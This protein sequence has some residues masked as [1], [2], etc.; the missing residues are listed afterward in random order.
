MTPEEWPTSTDPMA[1][2]AVMYLSQS[3]RKL[4][5]FAVACARRVASFMD[6][7]GDVAAMDTAEQ[8]ADGRASL[9]Q[10]RRLGQ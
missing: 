4:R 2:L 7:R 1:M 3:D 10:L 5:L 6:N 9:A 8:F